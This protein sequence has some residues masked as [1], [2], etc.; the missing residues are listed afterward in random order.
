MAAP[1]RVYA[2]LDGQYFGI[3]PS[4]RDRVYHNAEHKAGGPWELLELTPY[5]DPKE[6]KFTAR[7][8]EADRGLSMQPNGFI[9]ARP[10]GTSGAYEVFYATNQPEGRGILYKVERTPQD[11]ETGH[12]YFVQIESAS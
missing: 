4:R 8:V 6:G 7:F 9:E 1:I 3:D 2:S 10:A 12:A 5:G 11:R